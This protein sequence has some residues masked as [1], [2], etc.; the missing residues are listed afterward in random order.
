ME[1]IRKSRLIRGLFRMKITTKLKRLPGVK[2]AAGK[3]FGRYLLPT[4]RHDLEKL[5]TDELLSLMRHET[6]RIEKAVYNDLLITKHLL[7][8]E[9]RDR[10]DQIFRILKARGLSPDEPTVAWARMV[11]DG[12]DSLQEKFI[13]PGSTP[14][15]DFEPEASGPF[16]RFLEARRS[17]R[18]WADE[19]PDK[20]ALEKIARKMIDAARWSPNSGNR[21]AWRFKILHRP[22]E[23]KLL[24][25]LKER[26][27]VTAPLLIFVGMDSRLYGAM[28]TEERCIYIDAGAAI[29]QMVL[30]AHRCGLGTCW[31]HLGDDL[32][33]SRA[34]NKKIYG[35]FT[36]AMDIPIHTIPVAV[37]ALG[38]PAF[39]PPRPG[40]MEQADVL[41]GKIPKQ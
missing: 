36:E 2:W 1:T 6:H 16:L 27:C 21:Q 19:Q 33:N 18:V 10:L 34:I 29:M 13:N 23:R 14:P 30:V 20:E 12:F 9:K 8:E 37:I 32:I 5:S 11:H 24:A 39:I 41:I 35:R 40:R 38:R 3:L 25:K 15:P 31:N 22:E 7:F 28:G 26:H 4:S 17:V